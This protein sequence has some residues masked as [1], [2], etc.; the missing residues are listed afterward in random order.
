MKT[1]LK[2]K[3]NTFIIT[4]LFLLISYLICSTHETPTT[5]YISKRKIFCSTPFY[6]ILIVAFILIFFIM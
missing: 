1:N 3:I 2:N 5:G 4:V 6:L